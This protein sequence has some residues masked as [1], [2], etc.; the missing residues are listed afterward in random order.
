M[1]LR[2]RSSKDRAPESAGEQ[3]HPR[4]IHPQGS[5]RRKGGAWKVHDQV[6]AGMNPGLPVTSGFHTMTVRPRS[7]KDRAPESA[8]EQAHPRGIQP[9]RLLATTGRR[10]GGAWKVHD[11]VTAGMNPGLPVT[12]GFHTMRVRPRSSK[13]RAPE[14]AGEQAHPRGIHPQGSTR[15]KGGAWKVHDQV[16]AGM[17]PG[18][19]VTSGFHTMRV[20]PRSSKD[21]APDFGS[22]GCEFESCRGYH[23]RKINRLQPGGW[24]NW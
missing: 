9:P 15:R 6:T 18:L 17:N 19:P 24:R 1:G 5:T 2:P 12:S 3:A 21:R 20:R 13:D 4:G 22:G 14:S 16:T 23:P 7:S 11:Q 10:L 8:G